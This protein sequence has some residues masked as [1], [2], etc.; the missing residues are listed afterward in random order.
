MSNMI[1][2]HTWLVAYLFCEG[3]IVQLPQFSHRKLECANFSGKMS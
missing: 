3:D 2:D 1:S